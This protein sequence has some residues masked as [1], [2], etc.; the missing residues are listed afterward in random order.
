ML[1]QQPVTTI[2][3]WS[4]CRK[5]WT[6]RPASSTSFTNSAKA[7]R[8]C[9]SC[10]VCQLLPAG[11]L[12]RGEIRRSISAL[13]LA[14]SAAASAALR[15]TIQSGVGKSSWTSCFSIMPPLS[16]GALQAV[17]LRGDRRRL[18]DRQRAEIARAG[19]G[20]RPVRKVRIID[21][22]VGELALALVPPFGPLVGQRIGE[23]RG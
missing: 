15:S 19:E 14:L 18:G 21:V 3:Y 20:G 1:A 12:G 16:H 10:G 17:E 7:G 9:R 11:T 5:R 2:G 4:T 22:G 8:L 6:P 13:S 23:R